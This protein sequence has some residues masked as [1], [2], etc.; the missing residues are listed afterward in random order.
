MAVL[1][2][3]RTQS[4]KKSGWRGTFCR[5]VLREAREVEGRTDAAVD[6]VGEVVDKRLH[7]LREDMQVV[8]RLQRRCQHG[9][10]L[11]LP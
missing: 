10:V 9:L 3:V 11:R 6:S 8:G 7:E 5:D 2:A 1:H 4:G